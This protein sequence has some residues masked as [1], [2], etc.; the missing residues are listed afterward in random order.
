MATAFKFDARGLRLWERL[1]YRLPRDLPEAAEEEWRQ[2]T[3]FFFDR[4]QA[5]VHILSGDLKTSGRSD[6]HREGPATVVGEV[7]YG[8]VMGSEGFVDY[9]EYEARRGGDHDWMA[10]AWEQSEREFSD[11]LTRA[12][13]RVVRG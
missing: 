4:T 13:D 11:A 5:A 6:V 12:W 3:D 8:G 1:F 10:V 2:A 9:A 7:V